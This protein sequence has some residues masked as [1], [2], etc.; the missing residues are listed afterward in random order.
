MMTN[1]EFFVDNAAM[2][3][4]DVNVAKET[5]ATPF[6][7]TFNAVLSKA[8]ES[9][10]NSNENNKMTKENSFDL[11]KEQTSDNKESLENTQNINEPKENNRETLKNEE[12]YND[13]ELKNSTNEQVENQKTENKE[14]SQ[15]KSD[16]DQQKNHKVI[17]NENSKK[18]KKDF[19]GSNKQV[20]HLKNHIMNKDQLKK[21]NIDFDKKLLDKNLNLSDDSKQL[22]ELKK[23]F[24]QKKHEL[25]QTNNIKKQ[26]KEL[27]KKNQK[28]DVVEFKQKKHQKIDLK[29]INEDFM[30]F[31]KSKSKKTV[32]DLVDKV[33]KLKL[34]LKSIELK[35]EI[36]ITD[37]PL[38]KTN[39]V[40]EL[41]NANIIKLNQSKKNFKQQDKKNLISLDKTPKQVM[42]SQDMV[43][44]LKEN[45]ALFVKKDNIASF[46]EKK[47]KTFFKA[48]A[49][50]VETKKQLSLKE[51]LLANNETEKN[52]IELEFA[53]KVFSN[54]SQ[55]SKTFNLKENQI[56]NL[57]VE[58]LKKVDNVKLNFEVQNSEDLKVKN[59]KIDSLKNSEFI[60]KGREVEQKIMNQVLNKIRVDLKT[61]KSEINVK[62]N[63][64]ELGNMKINI[65]MEGN[66]LVAKVTVE[67]QNVKH[68]MENNISQLKQCLVE[69]N[70]KVNKLDVEINN[71]SANFDGGF[72]MNKSNDNQNG[73]Q[74]HLSNSDTEENDELF[75]V[76][77][78]EDTEENN[79]ENDLNNINGLEN[80]RLDYV[81]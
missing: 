33:E 68:A 43:G 4:S 54:E 19:D 35:T 49:T 31:E 11:V 62:L 81:V 1:V 75:D 26:P 65:K 16:T 34:N 10:S 41:M 76:F 73:T 40:S 2:V 64:P 25:N 55:S 74:N 60:N 52:D 7:E 18:K 47:S 79:N 61:G 70:I 67:N 27:I 17:K 63:P 5:V 51:K 30:V 23:M 46:D 32:L 8:N 29:N 72:S 58:P 56:K 53:K 36:K 13:N 59:E 20:K 77:S 42:V 44:K 9:V 37:E 80:G 50:D 48:K 22:L 12:T 14:M 66:Q 69:H 24:F 38:K 21:I 15:E 57:K 3:N 6:D 39:T 45:K 78:E 71:N 28:V